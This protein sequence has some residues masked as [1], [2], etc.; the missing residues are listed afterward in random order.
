MESTPKRFSLSMNS[1]GHSDD[2][3]KQIRLTPFNLLKSMKKKPRSDISDRENQE[4]ELEVQNQMFKN[5]S[6][7]SNGSTSST[8]NSASSP[9]SKNKFKNM[10]LKLIPECRLKYKLQNNG[11]EGTVSREQPVTESRWLVKRRKLYSFTD[12]NSEESSD[13][14]EM[15][16]SS[17]RMSHASGTNFRVPTKAMLKLYPF[18]ELRSDEG[19]ISAVDDCEDISDQ[20]TSFSSSI[21]DDITWFDDKVKNDRINLQQYIS[22]ASVGMETMIERSLNDMG[23]NTRLKSA[24]QNY[25]MYQIRQAISTGMLH[26]EWNIRN[27]LKKNEEL[28]LDVA[29]SYKIEL[30]EANDLKMKMQKRCEMMLSTV[31]KKMLKEFKEVSRLEKKMR[32]RKSSS[33]RNF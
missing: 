2:A 9:A 16:Q 11:T 17:D 4:R 13:G 8:S 25:V 7:S 14:E 12:N 1:S 22:Q 31:D 15:E 20:D 24:I 6:F 3:S 28:L 18:D 29:D 23:D 5:Q 10:V 21:L 30:S 26:L 32:N 33:S 27:T 19:A